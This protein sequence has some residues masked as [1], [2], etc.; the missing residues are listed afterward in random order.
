MS[1]ALYALGRVA[2]TIVFITFGVIQFTNIGSYIANPAVA[3]V[4]TLTNGVLSPTAIAYLV[5]IIDL[6]G[7]AL[8]LIG[9]MTRWVALVLFVFTG[10][11]IYFVHHFWDM[12]G[13]ARVGNQV[14][15]LKNL[16]IM[17]ALLM[18]MAMG[19]GRLSLDGRSSVADR[20]M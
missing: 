15:A 13:A 7:G 11:T 4:S 16:S 17:G 5:A 14:N 1:D 20:R 3:H 6:F 2:V 8:L 12:E 18:L 10:L 19:G 9:F